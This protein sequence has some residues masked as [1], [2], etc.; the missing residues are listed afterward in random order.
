MTNEA[1]LETPIRGKVARILNVRELALN[2]GQQDGTRV[3]MLFDI[4][5]ATGHEIEDPDTGEVI[6]SVNTP[7]VR[8]KVKLVEDRISIATT[9]KSKRVNIGGQGRG[10]AAVLGGFDTSPPQWVTEYETLR[11]NEDTLEEL[12][13]EDSYIATGDLA[14][15]VLEDGGDSLDEQ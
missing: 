1:P 4:L 6:G 3:G 10:I 9:Y 2:V 12:A 11:T 13:E 5:D 14:V 15:Q 8:V 7:K